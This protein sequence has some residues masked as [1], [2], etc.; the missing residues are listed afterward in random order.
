MRLI[1][2]IFALYLFLIFKYWVIPVKNPY[3]PVVD[4]TIISYTGS[5]DFTC[6]SSFMMTSFTL[7]VEEA[8]IAYGYNIK[9]KRKSPT[10]RCL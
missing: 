6:N 8:K 9:F 1:V 10:S 3:T 7:R 5:E 2:I 4:L